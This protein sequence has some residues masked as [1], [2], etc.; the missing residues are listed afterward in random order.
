MGDV[1]NINYP[2]S[3]I[4]ET[5]HLVLDVRVITNTT[6]YSGHVHVI[7]TPDFSDIG[8]NGILRP[9]DIGYYYPLPLYVYHIRVVSQYH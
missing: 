3:I 5:G 6:R 7:R 2:T 8:Q 4:T 9:T 1:F